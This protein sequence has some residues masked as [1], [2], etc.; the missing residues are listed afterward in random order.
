[1]GVDDPEWGQRVCAAVVLRAGAVLDLAT[2]RGWARQRIAIYKVP[3]RLRIVDALPRNAM[4]KV[5]K[6]EVKRLFAGAG[7]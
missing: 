4:G 1:V 2:L 7:A 3:T 5:T 6:P